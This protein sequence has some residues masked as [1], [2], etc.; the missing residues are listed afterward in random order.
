M[1]E[2]EINRFAEISGL[3]DTGKHVML[4]LHQSGCLNETAISHVLMRKDF[5]YHL[6]KGTRLIEAYEQLAAIYG[7]STRQVMRVVN[8]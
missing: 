7:M 1:G 2:R 6:Q 8:G 5:E 4:L 3:S